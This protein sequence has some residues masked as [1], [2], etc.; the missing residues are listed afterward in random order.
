M[1]TFRKRPV[2]VVTENDMVHH[3]NHYQSSTGLEARTVIDAFTEHLTGYEAVYTGHILRYILRWK[4]KNGLQDVKKA[5]EYCDYLIEK[6]EE[7]NN[8]EKEKI[9]HE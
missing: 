9:D 7:Q 3:P 8:T 2:E 5:R 1:A 6:L 4:K